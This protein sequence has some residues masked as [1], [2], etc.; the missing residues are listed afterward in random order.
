MEAAK[1]RL[2]VVDDDEMNL[3]MLA[4]RLERQGYQ[5]ERAANGPQ[6]L[7]FL[8][9]ERMDLVLLDH[10]MPHLT[11]LDVLR[12]VRLR[13]SAADLPVIMVTA[14]SDPKTV[15]DAVALGANDYVTKPLDFAVVLARIRAQLRAQTAG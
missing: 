14:A 12:I 9:Q 6:A 13:H 8:R 15:R 4:R 3:D 1:Q 10:Q 2:L 7:Q 11:G 5:V